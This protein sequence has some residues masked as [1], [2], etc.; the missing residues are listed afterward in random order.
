M[1][2]EMGRSFCFFEHGRLMTDTWEKELASSDLRFGASFIDPMFTWNFV[3]VFVLKSQVKRWNDGK[4]EDH[5]SIKDEL[6]DEKDALPFALSCPQKC[7]LG[8][9]V[10][11]F[12]EPFKEWP[13]MLIILPFTFL[14]F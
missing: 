11:M 2:M 3:G 7:F 4:K 1:R 6:N 10:I 9:L 14:D 8:P 13:E 12:C 5:K